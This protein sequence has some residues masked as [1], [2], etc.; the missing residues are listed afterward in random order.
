MEPFPASKGRYNLNPFS[1]NPSVNRI[2]PRP[3]KLKP[4]C[5]PLGKN[6]VNHAILS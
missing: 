2:L 1:L 6:L 3:T 5:S 4:S